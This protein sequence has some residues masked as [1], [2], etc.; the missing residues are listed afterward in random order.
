[1]E[2]VRVLARGDKPADLPPAWPG[3]YSG[4]IA[5]CSWVRG[6][7]TDPTAVGIAMQ[8]IDA[9]YHL[10]GLVSR[11]PREAHKMYA[12]H[13][14]GTRTVLDAAERA[15]VKRVIVASSSGTIGVSPER[16][17]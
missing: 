5:K 1:H 6:D 3:D 2:E 8:G 10:A 13:V 12:L 7:V 4:A 17:V 14:G 16:R 11:D 9:V 15:G